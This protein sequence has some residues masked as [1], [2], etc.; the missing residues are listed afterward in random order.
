M[1]ILCIT[2][3]F[4]LLLSVQVF[5]ASSLAVKKVTINGRV[6]PLGISA[7]DISFGWSATSDARGTQQQAYQVRV[8]TN[9]GL[10]D[11][12]DSGLIQSA[13]Q[14]A[15]SLPSSVQLQPATRYY[16]QVRIWD[17][18]GYTSDWSSPAWFETG[19]LTVSDWTGADWITR[20]S[21]SGTASLPLL[22][23]QFVARAAVASARVYASAQGL[24][25]VSINGQK[26]GD[27][28]LAPGWTNYNARIQ[29]QT[30]DITNLVQ[31]GT[32]VIGAALADGWF[33][34]KV[35]LDWT[36]QYGTQLAFIAKIKVTYADGSTDWFAT[37][38]SW[39]AGSGPYVAADL[40][41]GETYNANLE[42]SGW[43]TTA[44][45]ASGW[46]A[47]TTV[48]NVSSRLVPQ[49]DEPV[50]QVTVLT[51]KSRTQILPGTFIYDL[52]QNMVGV[53]KVRLS[54][55]AGQTITIRH[56][57]EIYR[58]G[59]QTG[60][61]YTANLRGAKATDTYTFAT[62]GTVTY[63]PKFT[64]HGFR[65]VE[66]TG[67]PTPPVAADVQ[68]I[69]I[70]SDLTEIGDLQTSNSML[71]QLV[72]NT[73]WGQRS[74]FLSIPT[75]TPA[76]DERLGWTGDISVFA[77][78][79][80]RYK[81]TR[82][83]LM[84]W[85]AD[86]RD[87]QKANGNIPAV[88]PQPGTQFDDTGVGW[89]DCFITVPYSV[90][91]ATG[92]EQIIRQNWTAMKAFYSFVYN[93]ATADGDLLEQGRSSWFSGDW[94]SLEANWNRLEEHKVIATAYFAEDTRMMS[95]MAAAMG[96][97]D[98]S[99]Q[100]AALVPQIH[101]A[102]VSAYRSVDGSIYQ[103]TQCAY[104]LALGM[105]MIAD[106]AQRDQTAARFV[107]KVAADN[108]HLQTGFL[109][110]PW[111]LPSLTG[112][113]RND[114]AFRLLLNQDY[115]SWGFPI[116]MGATT[117]WERWN[118]IQPDGTFGDASMNSFNHYAYGAVADWMF[119]NIG[120]IQALQ[121]GYKQSLIAPLI[122]YGGLTSAT[123]S[124]ETVFGRLATSWSI[125]GQNIALQVEV[126]VNTTAVVYVPANAGTT[127]YESGAPA[128]TANGVQLLQ[129]ENSRAQ[130]L[131]GSGTYV[132]TSAAPLLAPPSLGVTAG[133]TS[134]TLTWTTIQDAT[135]YN[136]KRSQTSGGPYTTIVSGVTG[137]SYTDTNLTSGTDYYYVVSAVDATRES[138]NSK[139]V[140][141]QPRF[142]LND[143]FETPVTSTFIYNPSGNAWTFSG[144]SGNGSGVSRDG[145]GFTASNPSAP[146]G[147]Q[148]AF[149]QKTGS[150]S[151]AITGLTPG[152]VYAVLFSAANR[153]T[154]SYNGGQSWD[155]RIDG[156]AIAS[157][158]PGAAGTTY[159][160]FSTA[161]RATAASHT[162]SFAGTNLNSGDTTVFIDN[163]RMIA[164]PANM[165]FGVTA[166]PDNAKVSLTWQAASSASSYKV[167]RSL[168]SG[169]PYA[170]V[171]AGVTGTTYID[172]A[173]SN[174]VTY[175]Y[176][177]SGV[178]A[179]GESDSYEASAA[180]NA[181]S[182]NIPNFGF[183]APA[184][185]S[186][187]YNPAG[188]SWTFSGAAGNGSGVTSNG[189]IF[190]SSNANAPQGVQVA[191][192]QKTGT[193]SQTLNGFAPGAVYTI[194]FSAANRATSGFNGAQS[195]SVKVGGTTIG[196]FANEP[197]T[198]TDYTASF[199]A[200]ATTQIVSFAG[201]A[202]S[203]RTVFLDFVRITGAVPPTPTGLAAVVSPSSSQIALSW[204]AIGGAM[205][206]IVKRADINSGPFAQIAVVTSTNYVD[207]TTL[208]GRS[209]YY[210]LDSLNS[211]GN[212]ADSLIVGATTY[213][214][215][216][217][218]RYSHF[219]VT[220]N[221]GAAADSAD[222]D[223]DGMTNVQERIAGTD[224]NDSAS[225]F[226]TGP[227]VINGHDV[228]VSFLTITGWHYRLETS[229]DLRVWT[230][231]Q[232]GIDGTG[233]VVQAIH[234]G[235]AI[236]SRRFY[237]VIV[238]AP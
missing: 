207:T 33:R 146:E 150:I 100:W 132:F 139:E 184:T 27:Q 71:N 25:E 9:A 7:L 86:V 87:T 143:G 24:Y 215:A 5:G 226:R 223:G 195:W 185:S 45:D 229:D 129:R 73:R 208:P 103:G 151:Q 170:T 231:V 84:K 234:F 163:V 228:L 173:V 4:H 211:V 164:A 131:V 106:A 213:S 171:A 69:V 121:P 101:S 63:Q 156:N 182:I 74:N 61:L 167:K 79:A 64:Q 153:A 110:T 83:F 113:G 166:T 114:L 34:G 140:V 15:V 133:R 214:S 194:T 127:V 82:A 31:T 41:D 107:E 116:S 108:Y 237:R 90:W 47:V 227:I 147:V 75:D 233:G 70:S 36:N 65:Y 178:D 148:V 46:L 19:L 2:L 126:P 181:I 44:F 96:E 168:T 191:F 161:F 39:K 29:S 10:Q 51:A 189:S 68:G 55:T 97:S 176:V 21:S 124:Q 154:S 59:S 62:S 122:G 102:F 232:D 202:S 111:L 26:A 50:R 217:N 162:L 6:N 136:V 28:F 92:D 22:R 40:Q 200:S 72:S 172:N 3:T 85:M 209:Y 123:C 169:G 145:S 141:A 93:S 95:E 188:S 16:W 23:G 35:G 216:E 180:P 32:N 125:S 149:L 58:T 165:P 77:P 43:N 54:G 14:V 135:G 118:S 212:S 183:E 144:S 199:T 196:T 238:T 99:A 88:V 193:I 20:P 179:T 222:P 81:D 76:R 190:T 109:G 11:V 205:G 94:L 187:I 221:T 204:N 119:G 128:Q 220:T 142:V 130:F 78:A 203:D 138:D 30:Y 1:A 155:V 175:Y 53:I 105:N 57:E 66:I 206:Y 37:N 230:T 157:Y 89:A 134:A 158:A 67:T 210:E 160:T 38:S 159:S 8:G 48:T 49:P 197:T 12:W 177:I 198:Y 174:G 224:P 56:G 235:G 17:T 115:P 201:T 104:D 192:L 98:Q 13:R 117:N 18:T 91:K 60:Q 218:W 52:G 112:I 42:H 120:G 219:G 152:T 186:F 236:L 137:T 225:L 80:A